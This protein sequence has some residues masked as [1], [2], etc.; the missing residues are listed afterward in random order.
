MN[1]NKARIYFNP[2]DIGIGLER[3]RCWTRFG[4][5]D[6]NGR[7]LVMRSNVNKRIFYWFINIEKL[8]HLDLKFFELIDSLQYLKPEKRI[9]RFFFTKY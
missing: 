2:D 3:V 6:V 1:K 8:Y 9:N 7:I 5:F 4:L